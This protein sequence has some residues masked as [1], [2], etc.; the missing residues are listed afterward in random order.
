[1]LGPRKVN[2]V[3]CRLLGYVSD[4]STTAPELLGRDLGSFL[5]LSCG[6]HGDGWGVATPGPEG[7][8][9]TK[10]LGRAHASEDLQETLSGLRSPATLLHLRWASLNLAVNLANTHPFSDGQVAFAHNGSVAPPARLD[11]LL[12]PAYRDRLGGDTDSERLFWAMVQRMEAMSPEEAIADTVTGAAA[13]CSFTS[14]NCMLLTPDAL[15]AAC[16]YDPSSIADDE[17]SDYYDLHYRVSPTAVVVASSGWP[18]SWESVGNG[19]LLRIERGTLELSRT[20]LR[21]PAAA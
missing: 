18:R 2:Q 3:V 8:R 20:D 9:V 16:L 21:T 11:Q 1:M 14:L 13:L 5:E 4:G 7:M 10:G 6:K 17:A 12:T 15:Y 19:Q